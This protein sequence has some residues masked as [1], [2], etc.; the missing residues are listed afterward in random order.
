VMQILDNNVVQPYLFSKSTDAH[1]LEI[2]IVIIAVGTVSG[3]GGMIIA[4][5]AYTIVRIIIFEFF[6]D[7]KFIKKIS[8]K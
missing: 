2:F 1:P 5:P 8:G 3:I 7:S 4:V 6:T